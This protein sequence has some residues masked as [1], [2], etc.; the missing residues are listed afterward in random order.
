MKAIETVAEI[1]GDGVLHLDIATGLEPGPHSVRLLV[2]EGR[3]E[4][5]AAH[6]QAP[7]ELLAAIDVGPWPAGLTLTR[8]EIYD[9]NGR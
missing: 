5:A 3:S 6:R 7:F 4:S 9:D 1:D 2:M 8:E